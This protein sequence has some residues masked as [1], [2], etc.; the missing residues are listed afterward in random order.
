MEPQERYEAITESKYQAVLDEEEIRES[1]IDEVLIDEELFSR[2]A[3]SYANSNM[4]SFLDYSVET[5]MRERTP[6]YKNGF[7]EDD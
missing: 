7:R 5:L 6:E 4:D 3:W 1:L 2:L